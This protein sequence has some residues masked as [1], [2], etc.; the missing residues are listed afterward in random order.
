MLCLA[1]IPADL[2]LNTLHFFHSNFALL[3]SWDFFCQETKRNIVSRLYSFSDIKSIFHSN[4]NTQV[5]QAYS[6]QVPLNLQYSLNT[7]STHQFQLIVLKVCIS[8]RRPCLL[9]WARDRNEI[10]ERGK[11]SSRGQ[12]WEKERTAWKGGK[13][14]HANKGWTIGEL[15]VSPPPSVALPRSP[16]QSQGRAF[17]QG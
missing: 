13:Q 5:Q 9:K 10:K 11:W 2:A 6:Q 16:S 1:S 8:N 17:R 12:G 7:Y 14:F 15:S 3:N 4:L